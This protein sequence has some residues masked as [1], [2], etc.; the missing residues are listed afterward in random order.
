[1]FNYFFHTDNGAIELDAEG[2]HLSSLSDVRSHAVAL[3]ADILNNGD[4]TATWA[5]TP[6]RI[7][8]TDKPVGAGWTY[9][10]LSI[11]IS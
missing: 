8:V 6:L 4:G 9:F 1:M 2:T 7:W 10:T 5:G 11:S 3:I